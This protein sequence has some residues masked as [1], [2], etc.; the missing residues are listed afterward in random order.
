MKPVMLAKWAATILAAGVALTSAAFSSS[1]YP[2]ARLL[3]LKSSAPLGKTPTIWATI[4]RNYLNNDAFLDS[5]AP[6]GPN[7]LMELPTLASSDSPV[8]NHR[9]F[10]NVSG[11]GKNPASIHPGIV[12]AIRPENGKTLW[13]QTLFNSLPSEPIVAN[14]R[15]YVG[16]GNAVFRSHLRFPLPAMS[17]STIRG[18]G[19]SAIYAMS[20]A[21]GKMLWKYATVGSDQPSPTYYGGRLYVVNGSR[22]LVVLN[23][24]TG[25]RLWHL[26]I[27]IYVSRSSPRIF[28]H[29]LYVGGGGPDAVA[30][31][32]LKQRRVVWRRSIL[33]AIGA[34]DDTPLALAGQRLYGEAMVGSPYLPLLSLRHRQVV[35]AINAK[36]GKIVW[37]RTLAYGFEPRYKQGSTPMIHGNQLFVGNAITGE[38]FALNRKTGAVLWKVK[39]PDPVTRPVVFVRNG[40]VGVTSHGLLFSMTAKGGFLRTLRLGN[41][42]NAFG[43]VLIDRTV[44]VTG[45]TPYNG[46]LAAVPLQRLLPIAFRKAI[47]RK[48]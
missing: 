18:T 19:P 7:Y 36:T 40:L 37:K 17:T 47:N 48:P 2:P 23:A 8:V 30:A 35:F 1:P 12:L 43:P 13:Q 22:Q 42:K 24:V 41:W 27:G 11:A 21:T 4:H 9:L 32:S 5:G 28:H 20:A 33:G 10:V 38:F 15:V 39:L 34:V 25:R 6:P 16:E 14:G 29:M 45:N 26:N 46:Y 44:F 3:W 31:I